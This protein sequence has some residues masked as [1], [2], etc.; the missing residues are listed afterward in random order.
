MA[1]NTARRTAAH[2]STAGPLSRSVLM[3]AVFCLVASGT[4]F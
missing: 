2:G 4:Y 3:F 1:G